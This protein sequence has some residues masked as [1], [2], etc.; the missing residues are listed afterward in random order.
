MSIDDVRQDESGVVAGVFKNEGAAA[1]AVSELID[2]H[3]DPPRDLSVIVSYHKEHEDVL[4][5]GRFEI[6]RT[7]KVGA[8]VGAALGAG[9]AGLVAAGL[10]AGPVGLLAAGPA[11][12]ALQGAYLGGAGGFALGAVAGLSLWKEEPDFDAADVHGV[13]WVGVHARGHRA[14]EAREI[15][16][17][18][19][20][21]H[22]M[23]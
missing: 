12:A 8:A 13:T 10:V 11:L 2:A 9:G 4:V 19:G 15:L 7:A 3:F 18:A 5:D 23:E 21:R 16:R 17:H 22:L 20:A 1:R 6:D 14:R